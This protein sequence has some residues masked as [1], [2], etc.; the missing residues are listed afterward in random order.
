VCVC[1]CVSVVSCD[2]ANHPHRV[3]H[4][5]T[6]FSPCLSMYPDLAG[7][8]ITGVDG[9]TTLVDIVSRDVACVVVVVDSRD[10]DTGAA[11][12]ATAAVAVAVVDDG[13]V[14]A[15]AS[16][17]TAAAV[18]CVVEIATDAGSLTVAVAVGAG[19]A[20]VGEDSA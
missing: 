17:T 19:V 10:G 1:V 12:V 3:T 6:P 11:V 20:G 14:V 15:G 9:A 5:I 7:T 13:A 8:A 16:V 18:D 2:H 4:L